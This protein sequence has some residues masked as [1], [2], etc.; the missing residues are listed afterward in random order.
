MGPLDQNVIESHLFLVTFSLFAYVV[1]LKAGL[2]KKKQ[3]K[4][5]YI[6]TFA[7]PT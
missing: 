6:V 4:P 1:V 7:P 3:K 2:K 5:E